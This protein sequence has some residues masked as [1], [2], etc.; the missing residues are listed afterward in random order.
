MS[1]SSTLLIFDGNVAATVAIG[2]TDVV[3]SG[4]STSSM[5]YARDQPGFRWN[6]RP[7]TDH[8]TSGTTSTIASQRC[9]RDQDMPSRITAARRMRVQG[10]AAKSMKPC[11]LGRDELDA[12]LVADVEA[13]LALDDAA[14]GRRAEQPHERALAAS[15]R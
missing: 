12:D 11:R 13:L 9:T 1:I 10:S 6:N 7:L 3:V 2:A 4:R 14:L 5:S 15:R 8:T